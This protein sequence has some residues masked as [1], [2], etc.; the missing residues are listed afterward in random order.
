MLDA[1]LRG[2]YRSWRGLSTE[3]T[4]EELSRHAGA[5]A[6]HGPKQRDRIATRYSVFAI[7]RATPPTSLE[8]WSPIG[9][10]RIS[11]IEINDPACSDIEAV[12]QTMG[13]PEILLEGKRLSADYLVFEFVFPQ[14]GIVLSVGKPLPATVPHRQKLLHVRLFAPATLQRYITEIGEPNPAGPVTHP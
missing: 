11:I 6:I 5:A 1:I 12:L 10:D 2:D 8:A 7:E 14:R 4:L 3:P 9:T 13:E